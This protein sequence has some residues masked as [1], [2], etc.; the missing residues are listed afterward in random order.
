MRTKALS[1][2]FVVACAALPAAA[3]ADAK[4]KKPSLT[5]RSSPR[6]A[7][8]PARVLFVAELSG[9]DDVE[10][11]Y[12]PE[13]EWEWDDG[14][15]SVQ[16]S[17]CEPFV[18]GQTK[19]ERRFSSEHEFRRAATY[20]VKVSLKRLGKTLVNQTVR[21]TVRPGAGDPTFESDN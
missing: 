12:C 10:E 2:L 17:D 3:G 15:K 5:L 7:F 21:L 9:G 1:V 19:I 20:S 4:L 6:F 14:S 11:Y 18:T 13:L 8:S 16:E